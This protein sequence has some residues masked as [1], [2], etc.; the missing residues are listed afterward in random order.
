MI[1][2]KNEKSFRS[3]ASKPFRKSEAF[4]KSLENS[5]N[6]QKNTEKIR[7]IVKLSN[8][9][10]ND[11]SKIIDMMRHHTEEIKKLHQKQDKHFAVETGDLIILCAQL[12][13]MENYSIGST[14]ETCY[15]R[16]D[17]KL[18][19]LIAQKK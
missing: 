19:E 6:F 15:T 14:I 2:S 13:M 11:S 10:G 18:N 16:F 17:K 1:L 8:K 5:T 7:H 12:L 3:E 9:L 4:S